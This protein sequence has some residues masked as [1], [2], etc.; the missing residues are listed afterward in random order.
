[1]YTATKRDPL[2]LAQSLRSLS[3]PFRETDAASFDQEFARRLGPLMDVGEN[4]KMA[5]AEII[6]QSLDLL[7]DA[8]YRPDPQLSL[9]MKAMTQSEE[10]MR[11]LYPP[12][13]SSSFADSA[14][15][16][17]KTLAAQ[18]LTQERI[19]DFARK[20][21]LHSGREALQNLPSLQEATGMWLRQ[22]KKGRF[23]VTVDTS[24]LEPHVE[25]LRGITQTLVVGL[26]TVGILI[27]SAIA[28]SVPEN[29]GIHGLRS[30]ADIGYA[31][32]LV[33]AVILVVSLL[34]RS[35]PRRRQ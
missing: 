28:G 10:F 16:I 3:E 11:V 5:L 15:E 19:A 1:M 24:R 6:S 8:G 25:A 32:S 18:S 9:A 29:S 21:A 2:A 23:E 20:Q 7:R 34:L 14:V 22:Y 17:T 26:L 13:S 33:L 31:V 35:R 27:S 12:G 30:V 4:E